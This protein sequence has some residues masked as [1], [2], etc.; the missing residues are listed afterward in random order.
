MADRKN[1]R[2]YSIETRLVHAGDADPRIEGALT[3]PIFQSSTFEFEPGESY[4]DIRYGRLSNTPTHHALHQKLASIEGG[5]NALVAAS[6]MAAISTSVL[7]FLKAGDHLLAQN[8]L[9]G[10]TWDLFTK[11]LPAFGVDVDFFDGRDPSGWKEKLRPE[12]KAIYAESI[13]NPLT[14]VADHEAIVAFAREHDLVSIIDNT[15]ASPINFRPIEHGYD[16]VVHSATKYLNGHTDL[17]AGAIIGSRANVTT[18]RRKMNHLGGSLDTHA[19]FLLTRG[20]KTLALRVR[21]QNATALELARSLDDNP[22]VL[23]VYYPGLESHPDHARAKT[24]LDGFGGMLTF[25]L[26]GDLAETERMISRLQLAIQA[27]SLGG[28]ETL[29]SRPAVT[30]HSGLNAEELRSAG[31]KNALVRV[32]VGIE[33]VDDLVAD[34]NAA[35][36]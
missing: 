17:I 20:L 12:T 10:G 34:F 32:S 21:Q 8:V 9:Y 14:G 13:T 1:D 6:G 26:K 23:R 5:E 24:L 4:H 31:I 28:L 11:D 33:S 30:S 36:E 25:E 27:P 2:E 29:V 35:L 3:T 18:I 15:F 7:A 22:K 19:C 16:V